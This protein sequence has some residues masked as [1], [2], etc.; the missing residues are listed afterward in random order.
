L[1]Q[2]SSAIM[3]LFE[4]IS[5]DLQGLDGWRYQRQISP[6]L[7]EYVEAVSF[8]CYLRNQRL[9]TPQEV[10][11][12]ISA[13][14][15]VHVDDYILGIF[16]LVGEMMRYAITA[17]ATSGSLPATGDT[18]TTKKRTI[19]TDLRL[20]RTQFEKLDTTTSKGTGLGKDIEKKMDVMK[21]CVEKVENSVYGMIIRGRERPAGWVP[22]IV[23]DK[24]TAEDL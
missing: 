14:V 3:K 23:D 8:D 12:G 7:Q 24:A 10:S 15:T 21:T 16:D 2:R 6:G 18:Q 5:P 20:L 1:D 17:M 9:T 22:D 11:Q 4:S 13:D 19:L